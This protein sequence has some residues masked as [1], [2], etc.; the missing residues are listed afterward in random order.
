MY[1]LWIVLK[2]HKFGL[3][4]TTQVVKKSHQKF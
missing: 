1:T 4:V 2:V 3:D